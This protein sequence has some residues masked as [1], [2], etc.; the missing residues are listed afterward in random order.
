MYWFFP[1]LFMVLTSV[2]KDLLRTILI[3]CCLASSI[4]C[5]STKLL[6]LEFKQVFPSEVFHNSFDLNNITNAS[7]LFI[8][9]QLETRDS[10]IDKISCFWPTILAT[11]TLL[12]SGSLLGSTSGICAEGDHSF[13]SFQRKLGPVNHWS[14][15]YLLFPIIPL[16]AWSGGLSL[17]ATY[18]HW[19]TT[20]FSLMIWMLFATN[21]LNLFD[22]FCKYPSITWLSVQ[23]YSL[24]MLYWSSSRMSFD[25]FTDNVA[26]VNSKPGI[27]TNL[28][29]ARCEFPITKS[30][31]ILIS[32]S[33]NLSYETWP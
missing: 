6:L 18:Y 24:S 33:T 12:I 21:I 11:A 27:E 16:D 23:K 13:V 14:I 5:T 30:Q 10:K 4:I 1:L 28:S 19:P 32:V 26:A 31:W 3:L 29:G 7:T 25:I 22:S 8:F 15:L 17:D 20:E 2:P 9:T